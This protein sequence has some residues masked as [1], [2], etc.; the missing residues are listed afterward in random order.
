MTFESAV[1]LYVSA[2]KWGKSQ[3]KGLR[4]FLSTCISGVARDFW[5]PVAV[6]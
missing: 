5:S 4:G 1:Y 2:V 3:D 6:V